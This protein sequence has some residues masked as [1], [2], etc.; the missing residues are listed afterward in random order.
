M[1]S[2]IPKFKKIGLGL[3]MWPL[4]LFIALS[5]L[6]A[7][8]S[9]SA[10]EAERV[11][12]RSFGSVPENLQM[13]LMDAPGQQYSYEVK[14]GT[15]YL[16]GSS[17]VALCKGFHDYILAEG[18][19]VATWSGNRLEFPT[20]LPD[21][22]KKTVVSPFDNHL[23]Y[24][25]CTFGYTSPF[26]GWEQWERE[27]D[28]LALHGFDMPLS[29]IGSEAILARVW[30]S[31]GLSREEIDDFFTG[32]AH[33]PWMRMGNMTHVDGG[34]SQA[35]FEEQIALEHRILDRMKALGMKPVF[36]GFCGF[37]P[38]T[39]KDHYPEVTLITTKWSGHESWMLDP[40]DS[41]FSAISTAF[42]KEWEKEFGRGE[43]YLIDSFNEVDIPFGEKGSQERFDKLH[44]YSATIYRSLAQANPEAVWV[45]Q[46]WMF[47]YQ[48]DIWDSRSVEALLS[49]V[50]DDKLQIIDLAVDFNHFVWKNG[51]SW[52]NLNGF[53]G[54]G[55]IWS[56]V[57]NF[58]GR[59]ALKGPVDFYL[60]GHLDALGSSSR[61]RLT[62][63]GA[64]PEGEESNEIIYEL[65]SSA[66]WSGAHQ[67]VDS[68][69][70]AFSRARYGAAPEGIQAFWKGMRESVYGNFTNNARFQWQQRPPYHRGETMAINAEYYKGIEA[71]MQETSLDASELYR[72]DAIQ[73]AALY[74]SAKADDVLH[75]LNRAL[76]LGHVEDARDLEAQLLEMLQEVDRLLE[77]H[78]ILRLDRWLEFADA[79][80]TCETEKEEF[81]REI[82]R[83]L[84][85]WSGP[86]L[87]DYSARVWSG[88]IRDWY[89]PRLRYYYDSVLEGKDP[90][91]VAYDQQFTDAALS[92][93]EAFP[94]PLSA[95]RQLV[96]KYSSVT[97]ERGQEVAYFCPQ[98][99]SGKSRKQLYVTMAATDFARMKGLEIRQVRGSGHITKATFKS[100]PL[101]LG[102]TTQVERTS[103]GFRVP[104][105]GPG[106]TTGMEREVVVYLTLE[107]G[108]D[109]YGMVYY[110]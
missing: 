88:L 47:G 37:V 3:S 11:I 13:E 72:V 46:G 85:V 90:D 76:V 17:Q 69:L 104:F 44:D 96:A 6:V 16:E 75:A 27:L 14:G 8:C 48:R 105:A 98:D 106:H 50:P 94:D 91:M 86:R 41:L 1:K 87:K 2:L 30:T 67:D 25:V 83:I 89:V 34:M 19:G 103:Q 35:W 81:R 92:K 61:G 97:Y 74:V 68:L 100:G 71:F 82:L 60:N 62:G 109:F 54:K 110:Y 43:Y 53:F 33:L 52:D 9:S 5:C 24:N 39:I 65:I 73:Y 84:S 15:L 101:Q 77:S 31:L 108:P 12:R 51:N 18:L 58:G 70:C 49:G 93:G 64:S 78:P 66:G 63:Y 99:F 36:Q 23:F 45:M 42:V 20:V 102:W 56:T 38:K 95:A 40:Q 29:P 28:W 55:W 21:C 26:W 22:A 79:A 59:S 80:A 10:R 57:P 32:P 4:G 107:G 7:S